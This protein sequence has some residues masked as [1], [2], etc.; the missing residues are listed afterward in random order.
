MGQWRFAQ[1]RGQVR[2]CILI[3]GGVAVSVAVA[4]A[5]MA[6]GPL[7][8]W[9][10]LQAGEVLPPLWLCALMWLAS[11]AVVGAAV[12]VLIVSPQ[13]GA[14]RQAS[15]WRGCTAMTVSVC[16]ALMWYVWLFGKGV[17]WGSWLCLP[18]A[19]AA[20]VA[21]VIAWWRVSVWATVAALGFGG[22]MAAVLVG[23]LVVMLHN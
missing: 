4:V 1:R 16:G 19:T 13:G 23:Q 6:G 8:M 21:G 2:P 5:V 17:V 18:V 11:F 7:R 9:H 14:A 3:G 12:G 10:E 20:A 22:E 15:L